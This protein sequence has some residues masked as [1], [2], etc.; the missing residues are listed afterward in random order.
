MECDTYGHIELHMVTS[1]NW[2][3]SYCYTRTRRTASNLPIGVLGPKHRL[4][5]YLRVSDLL[6][7]FA[8]PSEDDKRYCISIL[9]LEL[10]GDGTKKWR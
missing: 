9:S 10:D 5:A 2:S 1:L 4:G 6:F 3:G 8:H 7:L